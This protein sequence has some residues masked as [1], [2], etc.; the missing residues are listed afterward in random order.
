MIERYKTATV[1]EGLNHP[2]TQEVVI[3]LMATMYEEG[4]YAARMLQLPESARTAEKYIQVHGEAPFEVIDQSYEAA[5]HL[6][7]DRHTIGE[8]INNPEYFS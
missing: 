2:M 8:V 1:G 7:K 4:Y 3:G 6:W 5:H